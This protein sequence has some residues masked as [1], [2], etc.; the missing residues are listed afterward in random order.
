MIGYYSQPTYSGYWPLDD[1]WPPA[2]VGV[3]P[4]WRNPVTGEKEEI[5][6][7]FVLDPSIIPTSSGGTGSGSDTFAFFIGS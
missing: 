1:E 7:P 4:L 3:L 2:I 6:F 5:A